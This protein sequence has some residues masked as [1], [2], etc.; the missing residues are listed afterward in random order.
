MPKW[1]EGGWAGLPAAAPQ[2]TPYAEPVATPT[3]RDQFAMAAL[4]GFTN[5]V[6]GQQSPTTWAW[7]GLA[8]AAYRAADA[9]L[10]AREDK[11]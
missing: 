8:Q 7:D 4:T 11:P 5:Q 6:E 2:P 3:L 10:K 9:M 1:I